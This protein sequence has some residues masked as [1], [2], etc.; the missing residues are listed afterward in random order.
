MFK[1]IQQQNPRNVVAAAFA[2][3]LLLTLAGPRT[4]TD[5]IGEYVPYLDE[6][7]PCRRLPT[8]SN[9]SAHQSGLGRDA[10]LTGNPISVDVRTTPVPASP[11]G[12][13]VIT[14]ILANDSLG[15]VPVI[16]DPNQV[17][18]G[19][20]TNG[21]GLVFTP[22]NNLNTGGVNPNLG[23]TIPQ[24]NIRLLGPRQRCTHRVVFS[25]AQVA[26]NQL[27]ASG[28]TNVQAVYRNSIR[29]QTVP[30]PAATPIFNDQ[31]LWTGEVRSASVNIPL[32]AQ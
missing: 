29:G 19:G 17:I 1:T 23:A 16:Y 25:A 20:P 11:D 30:L 5:F 3:I 26:Q 22:Q 27:L 6:A 8:A 4:V 28:G 2:L 13:L 12:Q 9:R 18:V 10:S 31:G 21:L 32:A 24:S 7:V 14:L 15:M